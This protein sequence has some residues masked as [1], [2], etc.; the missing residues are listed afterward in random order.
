MKKML[1]VLCLVMMASLL[2]SAAPSTHYTVTLTNF[3][4]TWDLTLDKGNTAAGTTAPKIYV[5]GVH[6]PAGT[7]TG[8]LDTIGQK[9]GANAKVPPNDLF[10]SSQ[11]V[12]DIS[13]AEGFPSPIEFLLR[14]TNGCAA[15]AYTGGASFGGNF[16]IAADT[17]TVGPRAQKAGLKPMIPR[18]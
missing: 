5:W 2:A 10:G 6:D 14:V 12:L 9:H 17:C 16:F 7:C 4:D 8:A 3:C 15:A 11:A 18:R 13:D 1:L